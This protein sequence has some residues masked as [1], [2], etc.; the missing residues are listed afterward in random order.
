[1]GKIYIL[2]YLRKGLAN[3]IVDPTE[4]KAGQKRAEIK[5]NLKM[6]GTPVAGKTEF[7]KDFYMDGKTIELL[8]PADVKSLSRKAISRKSPEST[9]EIRLNCDYRPYVEF[10][11]EDL[12]WRYTPVSPRHK[13][14]HSWMALIAVKDDE[15][16]VVMKGSIKTVVLSMTEERYKEVFPASE[17]LNA[18]SH[19]QIDTTSDEFERKADEMS[20]E[21]FQKQ[22]NDILN[23][24][25]DCGISRILCTSKLEKSTTYT[26]LL[27][28]A[29]EL[30][31]L[32][33]LD[34]DLSTAKLTT[35]A[36]ADT[37]QE[38]QA[39]PEGMTF[40]V[41]TKWKI[42]TA[43]ADA[44][45][46]TLA[47]RLAHT[48]EKEY[49]DMKAYLD[50]D[51]SHSGLGSVV[52]EEGTTIDVPASLTMNQD[53]TDLREEDQSY[54]NA[55]K[56]TLQLNPVFEENESGKINMESD[57]W[58]V[59]PVYGAR[60]FLTTQEEFDKGVTSTDHEDGYHE[61][62]IV[63]DVNLQ[64]KNRIAAGMG[65]QIVKKNQEEFVN[66]AWK[67]V[68]VVN[69][70]NQ[71]IREFYQMNE[72]NEHAKERSPRSTIL[73]D[74]R[75]ITKENIGLLSDAAM[76]MLQSSGIYYNNVAPDTMLRE[77]VNLDTHENPVVRGGIPL[78]RLLQIY[79]KE[80][81]KDLQKKELTLQHIKQ[82]SKSN[83]IFYY[84][85]FKGYQFLQNLLKLNWDDKEETLY[86]TKA[87]EETLYP[88]NNHLLRNG[89]FG[90]AHSALTSLRQSK[91]SG[92]TYDLTDL[93][94]KLEEVAK[95]PLA[96]DPE[97]A[98]KKI[99][100]YKVQAISI[101]HNCG[102]A[103]IL[104][105]DAFSQLIANAELTDS[106]QG[107]PLGIEYW[108]PRHCVKSL[109]VL[110]PMTY[111]KK[112]MS[113]WKYSARYE[114]GT[115]FVSTSLNYVNGKFTWGTD[116]ESRTDSTDQ[117]QMDILQSILRFPTKQDFNETLINEIK[118]EI[119]ACKK[120]IDAGH[121]SY[122]VSDSKTGTKYTCDDL[123]RIQLVRHDKT[124]DV[125]FKG[126]E[127][128]WLVWNLDDPTTKGFLSIYLKTFMSIDYRKYKL[129]LE[130]VI[131]NIEKFNQ[132]I[133]QPTHIEI[134]NLTYADCKVIT[135]SEIV[136]RILADIDDDMLTTD[137][138]LPA[139]EEERKVI[140]AAFNTN[141]TPA[142]KQT[143]KHENIDS[144]IPDPDAL[145]KERIAEIY[146][147]YN[148]PEI[149]QLEDNLSSKY[150][151][152]VYPDFLDPTFFY[153][154]ELS[155]N[156]VLPGAGDLLKNTISCFYSNPKFEESLLMGMNTEMGHELL[157]REYP[158]DQRGSYFRKFWDQT[159]LPDKDEL[160]K[161]YDVKPVH[162][163]DK[164]LGHNHM[165]GKDQMLVFAIRGELMQAFPDTSVYLS[166]NKK[167]QLSK[168]IIKATMA[169]WLTED[170]YLVGFMGIKK[171]E[172]KNFFLVFEQMPMSLQFTEEKNGKIK[173][174]F[175]IENPCI[176]AIPAGK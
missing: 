110:M 18:A 49:D 88:N 85:D 132:L 99:S 158:T 86:Y 143:E 133:Q 124:L 24:N 4:E 26:L 51:I 111:A 63:N 144:D 36:W 159:N 135:A 5:V 145:A 3:N 142:G 105:D 64:L 172:L 169:S 94:S 127:H 83:E 89:A 53:P 67:K 116:F 173:D 115:S 152:M 170:T 6:K 45:F 136:D 149:N 154:R 74:K 156:Y 56:E 166:E 50:V 138:L 157:W 62:N 98:E 78:T 28:P 92:N 38:Q 174:H 134:S 43:S 31:R 117:A 81:W 95:H 7:P 54:R 122:Y 35:T 80:L 148:V 93:Y 32:S 128:P 69:A 52:V 1:M 121:T 151:V 60:H 16:K 17:L 65:S 12:P 146:K 150:P 103:F 33:A 37:L 23:E 162:M 13:D 40:P 141:A 75:L 125:S 163:W 55:L 126:N 102:W 164:P 19:V 104:Q 97:N 113:K 101:E 82:A 57:P 131:S 161:Y 96:F 73:K 108:N 112:N 167:G 39:R 107:K 22:V 147:K 48:S 76:K 21:E 153:L 155:V 165:E 25:P 160:D 77:A 27:I 168:N 87:E 15:F 123:D 84:D 20:N 140:E 9:G 44:N 68:E 11:E 2:P 106:I 91:G 41:Y 129:A 137:D 42:E 30:G 139:V 70:L 14:F 58:I 72:V 176:F 61:Y 71:L 34:L 130:K 10:Y 79:D 118:F 114:A 175:K 90:T 171:E 29:Y 120:L 47:N 46:I 119:E 8:G 66:R 100:P 109:L 59:P